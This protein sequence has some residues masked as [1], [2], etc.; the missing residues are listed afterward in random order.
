MNI[1]E[2]RLKQIITEEVELRL[3]KQTI[4]E[5]VGDMQLDITEEQRLI[6]EASVL[7]AL[8]KATGNN[9]G[10]ILTVA[11]L[12]GI[13]QVGKELQILDDVGVTP[14]FSQQLQNA[15]DSNDYIRALKDKELQKRIQVAIDRGT[16]EKGA[17]ISDDQ[18]AIVVDTFIDDHYDDL[19]ILASTSGPVTDP[20]GTPYV[21]VPYNSIV[22]KDPAYTDYTT[23]IE[24][25]DGKRERYQQQGPNKLKDLVQDLNMYGHGGHGK[26]KTVEIDGVMAKVLTPDFSA[27]VQGYVDK[28]KARSP[29]GRAASAEKPDETMTVTP[30]D[31]TE[32]NPELIKKTQQRAAKNIKNL[33]QKRK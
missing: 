25:I 15:Q 29:E 11:G 26:F 31:T 7:D 19:K 2:V 24:G 33:Q 13:S 27:A 16:A 22:D 28:Q 14:G 3:I 1:T 8:K 9:T 23:G 18:R 4:T 5:V 17:D 32:L 12:A 21:Y 6:L 10:L 30:D 20:M